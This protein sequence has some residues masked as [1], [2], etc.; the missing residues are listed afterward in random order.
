[1][2]VLAEKRDVWASS[3]NGQK[4]LGSVF[5]ISRVLKVLETHGVKVGRL[6]IALP[7]GHLPRAV[8]KELRMI[9]DVYDL[10]IEQLGEI[11]GIPS[12]GDPVPGISR[13]EARVTLYSGVKRALDIASATLLLLFLSPVIILTSV[14]VLIDVGWPFIFWQDRPGRYGVPFRLYKF[15]TMRAPVDAHGS[16]V[17]PD[18]RTSRLGGFVRRTRAD[19]LLQLF[20][21]LI[22]EMSMIGPRP[23]LPSDQP[24]DVDRRL[25]VRPG[26]TGWAQVNGGRLMPV[27]EKTALDL[28]YTE[29]MGPRLD[30]KIALLTAKTVIF[31]EYINLDA[32]DAAMARHT[33]PSA[34]GLSQDHTGRSDSQD[35]AS[36][37]SPAE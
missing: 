32:V 21:V 17:P 22:G 8:K 34:G 3:L 9:A 31:G 5:E 4:I 13:F 26:I 1:V 14:L 6:V 18:Q 20:N 30:L 25:S 36:G 10:Q 27:T 7:H 12:N 37:Q 15:R 11:L 2:G 24:E 33:Q 19:E 16:S 29:A 35:F 23:L 28:W